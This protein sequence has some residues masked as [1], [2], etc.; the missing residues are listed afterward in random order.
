M[1]N[2]SFSEDL[3]QLAFREGV[4]DLLTRSLQTAVYLQPDMSCYVPCNFPNAD[5]LEELRLFMSHVKPKDDERV[6]A[7]ST[8]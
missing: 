1:H 4:F 8:Q 6:L 5:A 2:G 7:G 3:D